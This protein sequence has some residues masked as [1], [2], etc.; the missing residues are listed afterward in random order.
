MCHTIATSTLTASES[1]VN[2]CTTGRFPYV[3]KLADFATT[4]QLRLRDSLLQE[5]QLVRSIESLSQDM[6]RLPVDIAVSSGFSR[7]DSLSL[8]GRDDANSNK[9]SLTANPNLYDEIA[10][11]A[12]LEQSINRDQYRLSI[13][14]SEERLR[15]LSGL[16]SVAE[17]KATLSLLDE[18][19]RLLEEKKRYLERRES[20]GD[21]VRDELF[22]IESS[23]RDIRSRL[24][25][26]DV[27]VISLAYSI[28]LSPEQLV[29]VAPLQMGEFPRPG[30]ACP[31]S[32][33]EVE[34]AKIEVEQARSQLALKERTLWPDISIYAEIE[35]NDAS[36]TSGRT[37]REFGI[38]FSY[39]IYNSGRRAL[40]IGRSE[41]ELMTAKERLEVARVKATQKLLEQHGVERLMTNNLAAISAQ[42]ASK[43]EKI[44]ELGRRLELGQSVFV[45]LTD[46]SLQLSDIQESYIHALADFYVSWIEFL[47]S[48]G[49]LL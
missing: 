2:P 5:S 31:A 41:A 29:L 46:A 8:S 9:L 34:E 18:R 49:T 43:L 32:N 28:D 13:S 36:S 6:I 10:R 20:L 27:R 47:H 39:P 7:S 42:A 21:S 15:I 3:Q 1:D 38:N 17:T 35:D 44:T 45:E 12:D 33:S 22:K 30:F 19:A 40:E 23:T 11:R 26:G 16:I 37:Q 14:K 4:K 24:V 25:A 48:R